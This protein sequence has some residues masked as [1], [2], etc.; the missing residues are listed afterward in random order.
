MLHRNLGEVILDYANDI[1]S[2]LSLN[3]AQV[4]KDQTNIS[5]E[6][7]KDG[8]LKSILM[9]VLKNYLEMLIWRCDKR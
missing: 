2:N 9:A 5:L 6:A 3:L 4:P 1:V 8:W 7:P